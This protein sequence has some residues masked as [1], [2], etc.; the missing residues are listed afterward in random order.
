MRGV[1]SKDEMFRN[2]KLPLPPR[3]CHSLHPHFSLLQ[4]F[5]VLLHLQLDISPPPNGTFFCLN[6]PS[7]FRYI[8]GLE[9][10]YFLF[11][12]TLLIGFVVSILQLW[13]CS[14]SVGSFQI[15][16]LPQMC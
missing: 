9:T 13:A 7:G 15:H 1:N 10:H 8:P 16:C 12:I 6:G 2:I 4:W 11:Q 14:V 5:L 3:A